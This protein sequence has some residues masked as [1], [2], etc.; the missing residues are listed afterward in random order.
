MVISLD[1]SIFSNVFVCQS[2][3]NKIPQT[4]WLKD[5]KVLSRSSRGWESKIHMSAG[6]VPSQGEDQSHKPSPSFWRFAGNLCHPLA[7]GSIAPVSALIL[8]WPSPCVPVSS[9]RFPAV[10]VCFWV[11]ISPFYRDTSHIGLG[12]T[13]MASLYLNHPWGFPGGSDGEEPACSTGDVGLI[14]GSA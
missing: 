14:P 3:C 2:C 8:T 9:G 13:L 6:L 10:H 5:K 11:Q 1:R 12:P 4:G 7:T